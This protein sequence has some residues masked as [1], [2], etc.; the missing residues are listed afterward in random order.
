[1]KGGLRSAFFFG[2]LV[3]QIPIDPSMLRFDKTADL[4]TDY[5][6]FRLN[7]GAPA[8]RSI[9]FSK[10]MPPAGVTEAV[11][12][13]VGQEHISFVAGI[14]AFLAGLPLQTER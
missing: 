11:K 3:V 14:L 4:S 7:D 9:L 12:A 10:S 2:A 8:T 5:Q 13:F 1:M 6:A